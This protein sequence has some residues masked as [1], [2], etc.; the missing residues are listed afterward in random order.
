MWA[1]HVG[2]RPPLIEGCP[3]P[4]EDL[5][6]RC[7]HKSPEERP[8]MDKVVEIMTI[9]SQ[10]FSGRLEPVEYA[11]S[12]ESEEIIENHDSKY[13]TENNGYV[14]NNTIK[15][16]VSNSKE[17][18]EIQ[19]DSSSNLLNDIKNPSSKNNNSV[20]DVPYKK[21]QINDFHNFMLNV[22]RI[23]GNFRVLN[24]QWNHLF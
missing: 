6:T 5:L 20:N 19:E 15:A 10:F 4:I 17:E 14:D 2:Q 21:R 18:S 11:P 7:W 12:A 24:L 16:S 1:V 8:S 23:L 22:I 3:K 13:D 9:L